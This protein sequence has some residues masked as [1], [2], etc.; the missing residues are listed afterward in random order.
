MTLIWLGL[1]VLE[2]EKDK[3]LKNPQKQ[4]TKKQKTSVLN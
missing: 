3:R 2:E 1:L 4:N